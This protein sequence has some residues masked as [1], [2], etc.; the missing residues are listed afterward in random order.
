MA[1]FKTFELFTSNAGALIE[2]YLPFHHKIVELIDKFELESM[3]NLLI[4]GRKGF[5]LDILWEEGFKCKF[6]LPKNEQIRRIP[7]L[8]GKNI[9][10]NDCHFLI[11]IDLHHPD[12]SKN[13]MDVSDFIKTIIQTK[14]IH[15]SRHVFVL[16]NAEMLYN[17]FSFRIILERFSHNAI[18]IC[19]TNNI[20]V[21]TPVGSRFLNIR[22]PLPSIEEVKEI[23]KHCD[24][25]LPVGIKTRDLIKALFISSL[26]NTTNNVGGFNY[27]YSYPPLALEFPSHPSID[28]LRELAY[29]ICQFNISLSDTAI[30]LVAELKR[31][32]R[33]TEYI[34]RFL[35]HAAEIDHRYALSKKG[36]EPIYMEC[37]LHAAAYGNC[38]EH[39]MDAP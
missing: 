1:S 7:Q 5:P 18:F 2:K 38:F 30:D 34:H 9:P 4:H 28:V 8:Y 27:D 3:P 17:E 14:C 20:I 19:T 32:K 24:G 12:I 39:F 25:S 37:L 35:H 11:E 29:K 15:M 13:M 21:G 22:V 33:P 16:K 6:K 23:V 10:Y 31:R 36:K 26:G